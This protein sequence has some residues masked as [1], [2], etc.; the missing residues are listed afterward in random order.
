MAPI[1]FIFTASVPL[2]AL[3]LA[4]LVAPPLQQG[5]ARL[6]EEAPL[7]RRPT[8]RQQ[9]DPVLLDPSPSKGG[10]PA[11]GASAPLAPSVE[12]GQ[13]MPL[14]QGSTPY[15]PSQLRLIFGNC[16]GAKSPKTDGQD[17]L[18]A[19]AAALTSRLIA[20]G[21]INSRVYIAAS[22]KGDSLEV[23]QG[24]IAEIR[25]RS[26]D[27][28]LAAMAQAKIRSLVGSVLYLPTL[29]RQLLLLK[30]LTG[31]GQVQ[32]NLGKV[33]TDP[34]QAVLT[35]T[36]VAERPPWQGLVE[37]RN[38]GDG[39]TGQWRSV[40]T[41][42]KHDLALRGDTFLVYGEV[43]GTTTPELGSSIGSISYSLPIS[44]NLRF[45][46][47]IG[48]SRRQVIEAS[49]VLRNLSY[50]QIQNLA[51]LEW[52]FKDSLTT[53]L[54]GFVGL[55]AN[56][57]DGFLN[58]QSAPVVVGGGAGGWLSSGYLRAGLGF[59]RIENTFTLAGSLYGIQGL[60]GFSTDSQLSELAF[61]GVNPGQA[62]AL[63]GQ[64]GLS[65]GPSRSLQFNVT[66]AGQWAFAPLTSDM[67]FSVGSNNGIR[68]LPG[69]LISGDSGLLG[70]AE[71]SWTIWRGKRHALQLVPF[72]GAGSVRSTRRGATINDGVGAAG[73]LGR[74]IAGQHWSLELGWVKQFSAE[75]NSGY[76]NNWL[77]G[78]GLYTK[79][80]YRF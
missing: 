10:P 4:Q 2:P 64:L 57:N 58:G 48:I 63:S 29:Q 11:P 50:R 36:L 17:G 40:A 77:L 14:I 6:P 27:P 71:A 15:S 18:K 52:V 35:L 26:A 19:C 54:Y 1:I 21:Y 62:K 53:R 30:G 9:R 67:T 8:P 38:D 12:P 65:W 44:T 74:L 69:S 79:L 23:V 41:L 39:G 33:G 72:V 16:L 13:A 80:Q 20:D 3:L 66:A 28:K 70:S 45:T 34:T 55:S 49:G 43:D 46:D 25:V 32:G 73:L 68:G 5:P 61:W 59:S 47:S 42:L 76:W 22:S 75:D 60:E 31:V 51:Q 37:I 7:D 56:R 78:S 24:R